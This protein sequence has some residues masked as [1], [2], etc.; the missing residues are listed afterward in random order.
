VR[1]LLNECVNAGVKAAF[2]GQ[3]V[4]MVS[5]TGWRSAKD[6]PLLA[7]AE[8]HFDVLIT[9]DRNLDK[10]HNLKK[11]KLGFV[12][13]RVPNNEIISY[14]PIFTA[15]LDAARSVKPGEVI[16]VISPKMRG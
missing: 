2:P 16:W 13:A 5:E 1:I 11:Y 3:A 14:Y 9:I 15:L 4:K 6:E 8:N 12:I 7:F 10:Q